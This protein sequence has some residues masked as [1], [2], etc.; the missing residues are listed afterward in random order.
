MGNPRT[1]AGIAVSHRASGVDTSAPGSRWSRC[2]GAT[3]RVAIAGM[4]N[5]RLAMQPRLTWCA[6][7]LALIARTARAEPTSTP[8]QARTTSLAMSVGGAALP[9][10][11]LS[12]VTAT[13]GV[14][15]ARGRVDARSSAL[16][17]RTTGQRD[18]SGVGF[19]FEERW[20]LTPR[21]QLGLGSM[22]SR[23]VIDGEGATLGIGALVTPAVV[24]LDSARHWELG[25][26]TFLVRE[27]MYGTLTPGF[28][29]TVGYCMR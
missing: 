4:K 29:F 25:L 8:E 1:T 9:G 5:S 16:F 10:T 28:Y 7:A 18:S 14:N 23:H 17:Y 21:Y 22:I 6:L 20:R 26:T 15:F 13:A 19:L 12:V 11:G 24:S 3:T 2:H 27:F